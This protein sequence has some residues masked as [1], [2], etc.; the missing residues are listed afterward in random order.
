MKTFR[1][2]L[3]TTR[4]YECMNVAACQADACPTENWE[5]CDESILTPP[6]KEPMRPLWI[7]TINGERV[8]FFG[9]M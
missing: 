6:G 2:K 9:W 7:E 1:N 4:D 8:Q 5:E 3:F